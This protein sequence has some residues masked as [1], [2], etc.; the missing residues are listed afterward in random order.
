[1]IPDRTLNQLAEET[2]SVSGLNAGLRQF[3]INFTQGSRAY[4]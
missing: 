1:M 3:Q 2:A 4:N